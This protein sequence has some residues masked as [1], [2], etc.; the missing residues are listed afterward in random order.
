MSNNKADGTREVLVFE[1]AADD[2]KS[3]IMRSES[4]ADAADAVTRAVATTGLEI[5]AILRDGEKYIVD[6]QTDREH[7]ALKTR[8]THRVG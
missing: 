6:V 2:S 5:L 4:G 8:F 7:A 1:C 3:T